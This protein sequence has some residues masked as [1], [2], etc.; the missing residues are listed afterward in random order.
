M[1]I[2]YYIFQF[3]ILGDMLGGASSA[4]SFLKGICTKGVRHWAQTLSIIWNTLK[5]I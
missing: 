5:N 2:I 1:L 4:N 3:C